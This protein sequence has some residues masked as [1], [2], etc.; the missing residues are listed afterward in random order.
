MAVVWSVKISEGGQLL[1]EG[2]VASPLGL[3]RQKAADE[4]LFSLKVE[5]DGRQRL[6]IARVFEVGVSRGHVFLE[7]VSE[8]R[9]RLTNESA[10]LGIQLENRRLAPQES[11]EFALPFALTVGRKLV[12]VQAVGSD[13]AQ[14]QALDAP[15]EPPGR[16]GMRSIDGEPLGGSARMEAESLVRWLQAA[17][18]VLHGAANSTEFFDSAAKALVDLLGMDAGHVLLRQGQHW[19]VQAQYTAP[20]VSEAASRSPSRL[21]LNR[22]Q[23]ERRTFWQAVKGMDQSQSLAAMQSLVAAPILD[24]RGEVIGVLYGDRGGAGRSGAFRPITKMEALLVELLAGGVAAGLSRLEHEQAALRA[25]VQFEQFFT[26]ELAHH[27]AVQPDLLKGREAEVTLL[28]CDIR[29]FSRISERLGPSGTVEW[30]STALEAFSDCVLAH[31]GVLVDYVGDEL[32]A[33]W[34]APVEQPDQAALACNAALG[35]LAQLPGLNERLRGLVAE[36]MGLGI[37]INTGVARVGNV[38]TKHKFKYGPL[39]NT[40]NLASR[41]QGATKFLKTRILITHST[42]ARL[43]PGFEVR[44]LAKVRVVGISEPVDLYELAQPGEPEWAGRKEM[45][46]EALGH[47]DTRNFHQAIRALGNL[48]ALYKGDGPSLLLLSRAVNALVEE[49]AAFDPVWDLPGK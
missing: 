34:G 9:V 29:G 30:V 25:Q 22:V 26:P 20:L 35:M 11:D 33:M 43:E 36:P 28:F 42:R 3:G 12:T 32:I 44:R 15:A 41:V 27:L 37:G 24:R 7:A 49:P 40:V 23:E 2:D 38:G 19:K 47:F 17:M 1:F 8:S 45:Y 13:T 39:G 16:V 48:L 10:T 14:L 18:D 31:R 6:A 5:P 21:V 4:G 46:E